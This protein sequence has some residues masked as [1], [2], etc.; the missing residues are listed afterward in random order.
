MSGYW[1]DIFSY[2]NGTIRNRKLGYF[3]QSDDAAVTAKIPLSG[4]VQW[5]PEGWGDGGQVKWLTAGAA[6]VRNPIEQLVVVGEFGQVLVLGS[7]DRHEE[8][9]GQGKKSPQNRGPL[10]GVRLIDGL[11]YAVGMDRQVYVRSKEGQWSEFEPHPATSSSDE[12]VVGFE[13]IDAYAANDIYA[14]GW[15]GEIQH[16]NGN[17][18]RLISSPVNTI[19][20]DV[21]CGGDGY[22]YACGRNGVLVR[23]KGETWETVDLAEFTEDVWN[24]AWYQDCLYLATFDNLFTLNKGELRV[25]NMG[26]DQAATC[27]RL[28]V[29]DGVLW[30]IGAKDVMAYDGNQWT[31]ID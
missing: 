20:V 27:G 6:V 11:V 30:S 8:T 4:I 15:D 12:K 26:S 10:R 5:T 29:G 9:I 24:L 22:V 2:V 28:A 17:V 13:A 31:R 25:V 19:L 1:T 14:V 16:F 7:G 3:I 18:W 23:G 21:C